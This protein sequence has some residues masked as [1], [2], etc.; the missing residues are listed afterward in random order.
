M[1][2]SEG[3]ET[4]FN[5]HLKPSAGVC[6]RMALA[7][8]IA[9]LLC[10]CSSLSPDIGGPVPTP[11]TARASVEGRNLPASTAAAEAP[12]NQVAGMED[13]DNRIRKARSELAR[14]QAEPALAIFTSV[15][16]S[17]PE[18]IP[19]LNGLGVALDM[20]GR[21][22]EA[23]TAYRQVLAIAPADMI[24]SNNL[25]LSLTLT[26]RYA[27]AMTVL[28]PIALGESASPRARQNLV[29]AM[30]LSGDRDGAAKL[31]RVDLREED[32]RLNLE[33]LSAM[34]R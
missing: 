1:R 5:N 26:G 18:N 12:A 9:G 11:A 3:R 20:L 32:V 6:R 2:S 16:A 34:R 7:G 31:A 10:A 23:Q 30:A 4:A 14:H 13:K 28:R 25:G 17:D 19:A 33:M 21:H 8:S 15:L 29:I 22:D 24:A 27:D